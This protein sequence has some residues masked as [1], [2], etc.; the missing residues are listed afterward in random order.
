[1]STALILAG[2]GSHISPNTA[3]LVW[4]LVDQLRA[5]NVADEVTAAFWKEMPSFHTVF[6]SLSA[7]DITVVPLFTAQGY[8][9]QTVIPAEMGLTGAITIRDGKTIR[10]TRTLSEHPYL[11]QVVRQRVENALDYFPTDS[12]AVAVIGHSTRRNPE[13]RKATEAQA[14]AL[15]ALGLVC[16]VVA[17]YLDDSPAI[18]DV[19]AMTTAPHIIAVPYFLAAG[20]HTMIDVPRELGFDPLPSEQDL[21]AGILRSIKGREVIYTQPVGIGDDLGEAILEL[22][23]EAGAPLKP[24]H[25]GSVWECFPTSQ[26]H[27]FRDWV[28]AKKTE[29]EVPPIWGQLAITREDVRHFE[30]RGADSTQRIDTPAELRQVIREHPFRPLATSDDLPRGWHV[31]RGEIPIYAVIETVYPGVFAHFLS[32]LADIQHGTWYDS[33]HTLFSETI[34]RQTGQYRQLETLTE[35]QKQAIVAR[36][37]E[38]CV[39][40]PMWLQWQNAAPKMHCFEPCNFWLSTAMKVIDDNEQDK[41]E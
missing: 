37:C 29:I 22:A 31:P 40:H 35:T 25:E 39:L 5:M 33:L 36:V 3:G 14:E 15:R 17:V 6:Q 4:T 11:G 41:A 10:Y 23:R 1:M 12:T 32:R 20:S 34:A 21:A 30:D 13:S 8:F 18:A 16:E 24:P 38:K 7:T 27:T 26:L 2:H 28:E 9:T 19:Y